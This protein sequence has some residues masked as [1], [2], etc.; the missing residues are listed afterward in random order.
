MMEHA[1]SKQRLIEVGWYVAVV[2][3]PDTAPLRC[4]CGEVQAV[5]PEGIRITLVDWFIGAA[6]S[7][8]L[9]VPHHNIES[10]LVCTDAHDRKGFGDAAGRWQATLEKK[11][12]EPD[13]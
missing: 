5:G 12:P 9:F 4:Y 6:C 10:M 11:E 3:K 8:D 13:K 7:W 1:G 2:L